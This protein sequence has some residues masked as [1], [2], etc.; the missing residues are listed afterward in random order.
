MD[1]QDHHLC[2]QCSLPFNTTTHRLI[3][4]SCGHEKCRQC[5]LSEDNG[6]EQCLTV[7]T[8][9]EIKGNFLQ[10]LDE[11]EEVEE[12]EQVVVEEEHHSQDGS[13]YWTDEVEPHQVITAEEE[14]EEPE[15]EF[16]ML[17]IDQQ[18]QAED[19]ELDNQLVIEEHK[20]SSPREI[21]YLD[22]KNTRPKR[23]NAGALGAAAKQLRAKKIKSS[24]AADSDPKSEFHENNLPAH[25]FKSEDDDKVFHCGIC[26]KS[27]GRKTVP[28]H[29]YCDPDIPKPFACTVCARRFR[30]VDHLRYHAGTHEQRS[31]FECAECPKKFLN[32]TTLNAHVR[33]THSNIPAPFNCDVCSKPFH[34]QAKFRQHMDIHE[35][36]KPY[37]CAL[38]PNRFRLKENLVKHQQV[39]HSDVRPFSCDICGTAFKRKSALNLHMQRVH[40]RDGVPNVY[41]CTQCARTFTHQTLLSRHMVSHQADAPQYKCKICQLVS[42]RKDNVTRHVKMMHF[43]G[44]ADLMGP[45]AQHVEEVKAAKVGDEIRV[46]FSG[47]KRKTR[48]K[49]VKV[50]EGA[51]KDDQMYD[52]TLVDVL[53]GDDQVV[54]E[55]NVNEEMVVIH[56]LGAEEDEEEEDVVLEEDHGMELEDDQQGQSGAGVV[57]EEEV[58]TESTP[59]SVLVKHENKSQESGKNRPIVVLKTMRNATS[60]PII[61]RNA[62][63]AV[64]Q[65]AMKGAEQ[66]RSK[67]PALRVVQK[68]KRGEEEDEFR[69]ISSDQMAIY[70]KI[71]MP[72]KEVGKKEGM[73]GGRGQKSAGTER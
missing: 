56:E 15:E 71:L 68:G 37:Q 20:G 53:E 21:I 23:I 63:G 47:T 40:P 39:T 46:E 58:E 69:N 10:D 31:R 9:S 38:C 54:E 41:P 28:Y 8:E 61:V 14:E 24:S 27:I 34:S 19:E 4:E 17:E 50:V 42:V 44:A 32:K 22:V 45:V 1:P 16:Y 12:E 3:R 7:T 64:K 18:Q 11:E 66:G 70:R 6:C 36:N 51:G 5:L 29:V 2:P 25:M 55:E 62:G 48:N 13:T 35:E 67:N 65:L 33:Q 72:S 73:S 49:K 30:T 59:T 52:Y 26:D 43:D 60:T 57:E